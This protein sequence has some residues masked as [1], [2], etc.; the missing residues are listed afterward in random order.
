MGSFDD[1]TSDPSQPVYYKVSAVNSVD[2]AGGALS[3]EVNFPATPGIQLLSINSMKTHGGAGTFGV[4]LPLDGSAIE[5][6][7]PGA[8]PGGATGD[9]QL[10]FHFANPVATVGSTSFAG[11]G[12]IASAAVQGGDYVV[13]LSSVA[14]AQRIS[15]TLTNVTDSAGH[16]AASVSGTMGVLI[17]DVN[18]SKRTDAGDV[19]QVRNKTVSIPDATTFRFDVNNSGRIDAGDVTTTRN[20][21]VTV[22]P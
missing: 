13:N 12:S 3:N 17:G 19:T 6:R 22:L 2:P 20:A 4:N 11:T 1:I 21:T 16:V 7:T 5:C 9:Y 15:V 10:V 8:L 14:N 18:A